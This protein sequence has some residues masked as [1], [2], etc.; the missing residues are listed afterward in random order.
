M[1]KNFVKNQKI[2]AGI[3]QREHKKNKYKYLERARKRRALKRNAEHDNYM[4]WLKEIKSKRKFICYWCGKKVATNR[5]HVDHI[6]PLS[7]GGNDT[8]DNVCASCDKCNM[9]KHDKMP[10]DFVITGQQVMNF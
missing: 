5:L 4:P 2:A 10:F 7:K 9:A 6:I 1:Q 8:W 3:I